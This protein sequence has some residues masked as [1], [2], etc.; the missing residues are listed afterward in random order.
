MNYRLLGAGPQRATRGLFHRVDPPFRTQ[1]WARLHGPARQHP[2][3]Q[4][5]AAQAWKA[6]SSGCFFHKREEK[7]FMIQLQVKQRDALLFL[8]S[9]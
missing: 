7:P 6:F 1:Q 8:A 4:E 9:P 3:G 5:D 2:G